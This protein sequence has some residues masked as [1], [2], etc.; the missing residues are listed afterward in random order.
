M[1]QYNA[2]RD[3]KRNMNVIDERGYGHLTIARID[4]AEIETLSFAR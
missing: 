2:S 4:G 3:G 1:D